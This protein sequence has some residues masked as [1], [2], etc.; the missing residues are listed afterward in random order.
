MPIQKRSVNQTCWVLW[1]FHPTSPH[2]TLKKTPQRLQLSLYWFKRWT[3]SKQRYRFLLNPCARIKGTHWFDVS[4]CHPESAYDETGN[5]KTNQQR[6]KQTRLSDTM[7]Q[8][9][10][11]REQRE[12]I[13]AVTKK[14]ALPFFPLWNQCPRFVGRKRTGSEVMSDS[15]RSQL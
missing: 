9:K 15:S 2:P 13:L 6:H 3:L 5:D 12:V 1:H 14:K 11:V 7:N 8:R 10:G 4:T